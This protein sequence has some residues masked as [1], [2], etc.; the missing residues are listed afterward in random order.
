MLFQV[1]GAS[2]GVLLGGTQNE[3]LGDSWSL[4]PERCKEGK[5]WY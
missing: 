2:F 4:S 1:G 3:D 5:Q